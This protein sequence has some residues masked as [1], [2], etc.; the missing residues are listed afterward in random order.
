MKRKSLIL[1]ALLA[2]LVIVVVYAFTFKYYDDR[3]GG[4]IVLGNS[5][6]TQNEFIFKINNAKEIA[7]VMDVRNITQ[8]G[9]VKVYECGVG[10]ASSLGLLNKTVRNFAIDDNTC[11]KND[12]NETSIAECNEIIHKSGYIIYLKGVE[13][14]SK[15]VKYYEDHL[16]I[17]VPKNNQNKC[18]IYAK[19]Q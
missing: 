18:G 3:K 14:D 7:I 1:L 12:L 9:K 6:I 15:E 2:V 19:N 16:M 8:D 13:D 17:E 5:T 10:F 11:V 4:D